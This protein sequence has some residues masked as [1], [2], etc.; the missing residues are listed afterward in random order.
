MII[1]ALVFLILGFIE[2][3]IVQI[4]IYPALRARFEA[5]KVTASQGADPSRIMNFVKFQSLIL[6]PII[7][8]YMGNS[9]QVTGG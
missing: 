2:L 7:G 3:M 8:F 6:M 5:A 4:M 1:G 9:F